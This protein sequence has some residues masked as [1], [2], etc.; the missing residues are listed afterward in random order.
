MA[1]LSIIYCS[2]NI[3]YLAT[4]PFHIVSILAYISAPITIGMVSAQYEYSKLT[5]KYVYC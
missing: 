5:A 4:I 1:L 2:S 3:L